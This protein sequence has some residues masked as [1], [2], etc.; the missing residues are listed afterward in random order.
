[1]KLSSYQKTVLLL[2]ALTQFTVVLDFM[3]MA[4]LGEELISDLK[5]TTRQFGTVVSVYAI[6]AALSSFLSAAFADRYD[7]KNLLLFFYAG[8]VVGTFFCGLATTYTFMLLARII[9][10]VFGGVIGSVSLAIVADCFDASVR[11]RVMGTIQMAFSV[12]QVVGI[13]TGLWIAHQWN[14]HFTFYSV[15]VFTLL[16]GLA[17]G[18]FLKPLKNHLL[19][20]SNQ[21]PVQHVIATLL[22]RKHRIGFMATSVL[23]LG[24]FL[25]MPFTTTY[26]VNNVK[27]S[28]GELPLIFMVT[29]LATM[30]FLPMIGKLSD[31]IN[32]MTLFIGGSILAMFM[33][34]VF[35]RMEPMSYCWVMLINVVLF[36]GIMS[37]MVPAMAL[38]AQIPE[39]KY[40]GAF[41]SVNASIQQFSGG[42]A[43]YLAGHIV[44]QHQ[45][46]APLLHFEW[47]GN[48]MVLLM[49]TCIYL[50]YRVYKAVS[51]PLN[52]S[53]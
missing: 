45:P 48:V 47:L 22:N 18:L 17:L 1:M 40:R 25:I 51:I 16:V 43:S 4:P 38:N 6:S 28:A 7:R 27:V 37:R 15:A 21:N 9:T 32:R 31:R 2:L 42:I 26:L 11:G 39:P 3:I 46:D 13:P 35:T 24:G 34:S 29:G 50:V 49:L 19:P 8:F 53:L 36:A 10:G 14:W 5:L 12:S 52:P 33:V 44:V 30:V 41:M 23:S 20:N